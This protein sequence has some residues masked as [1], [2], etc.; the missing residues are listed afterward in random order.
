MDMERMAEL[1]DLARP[2]QVTFHRAFDMASDPLRALEDVIS[3]GIERILT[4]GQQAT[5]VEGA[6]LIRE[7]VQQSAGRVSIMAGSGVSEKNVAELVQLTG[8]KEVHASLRSKITS[9]MEFKGADVSM[10]AGNSDEFRWLETDPRKVKS[11]MEKL[12][13]LSL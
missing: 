1:L 3:L 4:S 9:R 5:A 2:M 8:V 11:V 10:D 13:S 7:L 6:G 12:R